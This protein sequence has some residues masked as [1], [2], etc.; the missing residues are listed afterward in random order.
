M[1]NLT[2]NSSL[3]NGSGKDTDKT[4]DVR[5]VEVNLITESIAVY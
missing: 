1:Q 5:A 2:V 3:Q 4:Q